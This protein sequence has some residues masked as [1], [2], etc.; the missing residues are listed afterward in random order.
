M[1]KTFVVLSAAG[2]Q[3]DLTK[4]AREQAHWGEHARFID[5]ITEGFILMGGPFEDE[6]GAMLIVRAENEAAVRAKLMPDPWYTHGIIQ[7]QSIHRWDIFIDERASSERAPIWG[8]TGMTDQTHV[9]APNDGR[10]DFDFLNGKWHSRHRKL[11]RRLAGCDEWD[12]FTGVTV[13][14]KIRDGLGQ[15]DEVTLE[16]PGG[17]VV[18]TTVRLFDPRT[19]QWSLYWADSVNGWNWRLPQIG[20]FKEGR[21]EFYAHEPFEGR[22]IFSRFIWTSSGPDTC[23]WEQAFSDD[24]GRTWETNWTMDFQRIS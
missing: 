12:E 16:T 17:R 9:A 20:A 15:F 19:R 6:G 7:L 21:G 14:Y 18:G 3:R 24:A 13:A 11:K 2:A 22:Y 4:G 8:R 1:S 5:G 10:N 23:R